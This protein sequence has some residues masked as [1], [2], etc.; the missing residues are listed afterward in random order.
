[1]LIVRAFSGNISVSTRD[2]EYGS[3]IDEVDG[4]FLVNRNS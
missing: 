1:M 4:R 3:T 2:D